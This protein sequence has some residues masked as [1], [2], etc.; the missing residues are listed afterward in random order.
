MAKRDE[1]YLQFPISLMRDLVEDKA[2]TLGKIIDAGIVKVSD[3]IKISWQDASRQVIYDL[4]RSS[5]KLC[6]DL[7]TQ[8]RYLE[9]EII[10]RNDD[11]ATFSGRQRLH[12]VVF[13]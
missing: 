5:N 10:G 9:S 7:K 6:N 3:G 13:G 2:G 1:R 4:Y 12:I 11:Q 8:L